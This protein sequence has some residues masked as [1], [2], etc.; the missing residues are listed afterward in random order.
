V[1]A[2]RTIEPDCRSAMVGSTAS[3]ART[4]P[5]TSTSNALCQYFSLPRPPPAELIGIRMSQPSRASIAQASH[6]L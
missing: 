6:A 5:I 1:V 2:I 3:T 4:G